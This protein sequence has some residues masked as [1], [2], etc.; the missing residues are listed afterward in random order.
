MANR[1]ISELGLN[2]NPKGD[3]LLVIV[4]NNETEKITLSGIT[5]YITSGITNSTTF[6]GTVKEFY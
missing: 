4:N 1:K 2:N 3:D 6:S 5:N